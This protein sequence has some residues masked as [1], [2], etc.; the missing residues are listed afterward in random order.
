MYLFVCLPVHSSTIQLSIPYFQ[1]HAHALVTINSAFSSSKY[2]PHY[3][4]TKSSETSLT[5]KYKFTCRRHSYSQLV[6]IS[7]QYHLPRNLLC[8]VVIGNISQYTIHVLDISNF[9]VWEVLYWELPSLA[10]FLDFPFSNNK[11]SLLCCGKLMC[12]IM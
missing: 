4:L 12:L 7:Q 5:S 1:P 10:T 3:Y 2:T 9:M 11:F 6:D 8:L